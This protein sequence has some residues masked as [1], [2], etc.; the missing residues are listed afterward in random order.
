MSSKSKES[1]PKLDEP[2]INNMWG[3]TFAGDLAIKEIIK[4]A[5]IIVGDSR[6][7]KS[8]LLNYLSKVPMEG[9]KIKRKDIQLK[10]IFQE[11]NGVE[12]DCSFASCTLVPNIKNM[13]VGDELVSVVDTAGFND[14]G[15]SYVGT[16]GV[17]Y[18]L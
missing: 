3:C 13:Q 10:V 17:S 9:V 11:E 6:S 8:T 16:F 12:V 7:G 15:R 14:E 2:N 4:K 5:I 18:M 1:S